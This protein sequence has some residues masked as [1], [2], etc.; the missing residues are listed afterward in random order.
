MG[1]PLGDTTLTVGSSIMLNLLGEA[2]G[3][4]GVRMGG[5][6]AGAVY[7]CRFRARQFAVA[8]SPPSLH[9]APRWCASMQRA[10]RTRGTKLAGA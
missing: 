5:W 7:R 8:S 3:E 6:R 9:H 2:D 4:E 10:V 1:W